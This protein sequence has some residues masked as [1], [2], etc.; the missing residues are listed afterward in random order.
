VT[1]L[2][3]AFLIRPDGRLA[4]VDI[5]TNVLHSTV[6]SLIA[7]HAMAEAS[8]LDNM[9]QL[10]DLSV[11]QTRLRLDLQFVQKQL[12]DLEKKQFADFERVADPIGSEYSE[13]I[14]DMVL[15]AKATRDVRADELLLYHA[16]GI[17]R[18]KDTRPELATEGECWYFQPDREIKKGEAFT[19]LPAE[20]AG[21]DP[22]P[23]GRNPKEPR[24][25]KIDI[26]GRPAKP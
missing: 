3:A 20:S 1:K 21:G 23:Q 6:A 7:P 9:Q 16:P 10:F 8:D 14:S 5:S 18:V 19:I 25:V 24:R 11:K 2:P 4:A 17:Y 15:R 13:S 26:P 12:D 22:Q